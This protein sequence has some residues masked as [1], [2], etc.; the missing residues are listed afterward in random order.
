MVLIGE[1]ATGAG[2]ERSYV[3]G[4]WTRP[5]AGRGGW[6]DGDATETEADD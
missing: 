6:D 1:A 5:R 3:Y 2:Y 4:D